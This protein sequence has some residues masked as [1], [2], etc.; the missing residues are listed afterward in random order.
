MAI[1]SEQFSNIEKARI[2][3]ILASALLLAYMAYVVVGGL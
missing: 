2:A 3:V 1:P